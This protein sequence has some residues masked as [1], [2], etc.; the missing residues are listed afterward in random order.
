MLAAAPWSQSS[1]KTRSLPLCHERHVSQPVRRL[2]LP[3]PLRLL[4]SPAAGA[5]LGAKH[6]HPGL[7]AGLRPRPAGQDKGERGHVCPG[8][9][10]LQP[11]QPRPLAP[12]HPLGAA[13]P[14][15]TGR[16]PVRAHG[17]RQA[18]ERHGLLLLRLPHRLLR[19]PDGG[20]QLRP[21]GQQPPLPGAAAPLPVDL[22]WCS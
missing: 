11:A 2:R 4:Q 12:H 1:Q 17:E 19:L 13:Q 16:Q 21:P 22:R 6:A 20:V 10:R 5:R 7:G 3:H 8:Q 9:H 15:A 14:L 18:P